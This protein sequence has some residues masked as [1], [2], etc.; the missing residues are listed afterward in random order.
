MKLYGKEL[1][2]L[3]IALVIVTLI[4]AAAFFVFYAI[5]SSKLKKQLEIEYGKKE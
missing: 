5:R 4:I 3:G 1:L 2:F